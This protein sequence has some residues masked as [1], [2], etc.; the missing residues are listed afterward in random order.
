MTLG[1]CFASVIS[2]DHFDSLSANDF[3]NSIAYYKGITFQPNRNWIS[4][5][6]TKIE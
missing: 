6:S 2:T 4:K 3:K 1:Q 5:L